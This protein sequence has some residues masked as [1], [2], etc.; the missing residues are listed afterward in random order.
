MKLLQ[1]G[2]AAILAMILS[3]QGMVT[4]YA[5]AAEPVSTQSEDG[6]TFTQNA[7]G[8]VTATIYP[9]LELEALS[10]DLTAN[11]LE[12]CGDSYIKTSE[13]INLSLGKTYRDGEM[14]VSIESNGTGISFYPETTAGKEEELPEEDA[15][16]SE[17]EAELPTSAPQQE[18]PVPDPSVPELVEDPPAPEEPVTQGS[19]AP[20]SEAP[21]EAGPEPP[22][23]PEEA[24]EEAQEEAAINTEQPAWPP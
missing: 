5:E 11:C 17:P 21:V 18:T 10:A 9:S 20:D 7:D 4:A 3:M 16:A 1:K 14:L 22:Q 19:P 6:V 12:D 13:K 24:L 8:T 23:I 2:M 15:A